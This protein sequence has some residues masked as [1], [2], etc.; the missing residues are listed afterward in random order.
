MVEY[1]G[2]VI[3]SG[4]IDPSL[5]TFFLEKTMSLL[6]TPINELSYRTRYQIEL[7][8]QCMAGRKLS[9]ISTCQYPDHLSELSE[10]LDKLKYAYKEF[11]GSEMDIEALKEIYVSE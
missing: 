1:Y 7:A 10:D 3:V 6:N 9:W 2:R 8:L 11:T 5:L 4:G